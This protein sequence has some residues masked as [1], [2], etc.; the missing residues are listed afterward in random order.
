[1]IS[2]GLI[3]FAFTKQSHPKIRFSEQKK[4]KW[5]EEKQDLSKNIQRKFPFQKKKNIS[6]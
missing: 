2:S 4:K 6:T 3:P 1:M 5:K